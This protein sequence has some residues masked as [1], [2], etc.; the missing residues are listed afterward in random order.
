MKKKS[1]PY[2]F[3]F[4]TFFLEVTSS[5]SQQIIMDR[6]K[7][8]TDFVFK[9][10]HI[11]FNFSQL[12]TFKAQA[13]KQSGQHI[14]NTKPSSGFLISFK[15]AINF[16][17]Q[18]SL[19]SGFELIMPSRNFITSFDKDD[20]TPPLLMDYKLKKGN[21][22]I[23]D[24]IFSIPVLVEKR[25][26]YKKRKSFF[27]NTGIRFNTSTGADL[28]VFPIILSNTNNTFYDAGGVYVYANNDAKP[29]ISFPIN[30]GHSWLLKNNNLLQ[31]AICSNI[32]FTKYVDGIYEIAIPGKPL[33]TGLYSSKGSFVGLSMNYVFTN[34]NYRIRKAYE[35]Q[36]TIK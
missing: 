20:F 25:W 31:L 34:A 24:L 3:F 21:S 18:Y 4:L 29:W 17:N 8:L 16:N 26:L 36:A 13:K 1:I 9:G 6:E 12:A 7:F 35:K 28:D 11:Q 27:T 5:A 10:N 33:T 30:V 22:K 32:S 14:V 19:I 2:S 15:Y 23:S